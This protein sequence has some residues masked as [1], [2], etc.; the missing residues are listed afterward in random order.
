MQAMDECMCLTN[1]VLHLAHVFPSSIR[2]LV[3]AGDTAL[4]GAPSLGAAGTA[5]KVDAGGGARRAVDAV[6]HQS[7]GL[8]DRRERGRYRCGLCHFC[9]FGEWCRGRADGSGREDNFDA[10]LA[11]ST[12]D[13]RAF[14]AFAFV[15]ARISIGLFV[16]VVS[17]RAVYDDHAGHLVVVVVFGP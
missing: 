9:S 4:T 10:E 8:F 1:A 11:L 12:R 5:G 13:H 17:H 3:H 16:V 2:E 7:R 6:A 15:L 14:F